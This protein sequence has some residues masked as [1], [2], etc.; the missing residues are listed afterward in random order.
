MLL[1]DSST[2]GKAPPPPHYSPA[3]APDH[4]MSPQ[5]VLKEVGGEIQA[6]IPLVVAQLLA[7]AQLSR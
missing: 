4:P 5:A 7:L 2:R 1:P 6:H 3:P